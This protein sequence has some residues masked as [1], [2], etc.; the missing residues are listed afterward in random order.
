MAD[1]VPVSTSEINLSKDRISTGA[2]F[3]AVLSKP[4]SG[5]DMYKLT[6]KLRLRM[7]Q[8]YQVPPVVTDAN[9]DPF[10]I[11]PWTGPEWHAYINALRTQ[12]DLWND[13]FWL[14]PPGDFTD[15]DLEIMSTNR[16][17]RPYIACELDVDFNADRA[18]AHRTIDVYNL[19][20][21]KITGSKDSGT[22]RS[23]SMHYD[24]L[25]G[26]PYV[27]E[28][29][30]DGG[31][32]MMHYTVAH[33]IGHAIGQPHIGVMKKTP[34]CQFMMNA[35]GH[36]GQNSG[37]CYGDDQPNLG[38]NI[39]G[40]GSAFSEVNAISWKWA[41]LMLTGKPYLNWQVLTSKPSGAG[42]WVTRQ[43]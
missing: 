36:E 4:T 31:R 8:Y 30:D 15:F 20:L 42:E 28:Y 40:G 41:I 27:T 5:L 21:S 25:D 24:S 37:I 26:T 13:Q 11:R 38:K 16:S 35:A 29:I 14:R 10:F 19:D 1:Y 6:L 43:L 9:G 2:T 7:Q 12:A 32:P 3:D 23:D 39:M 33:E 17:F 18:D 34:L 22:F